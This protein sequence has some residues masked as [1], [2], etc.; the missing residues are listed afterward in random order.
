MAQT[1]LGLHHVTATVGDAQQDLDFCIDLLGLRLVKKT[2]NLDNEKV[3][4]FYYGDEGGTPGSLWT[5]LP[6]AGQGVAKGEKGAGQ[7]VATSFSVPQGSLP[8]WQARFRQHRVLAAPGRARFADE[9]IVFQD[10][11][12]LVFELIADADDRTPWESTIDADHAIRGLHSVTMVVQDPGPTTAFMQ[13]ALGFDV[14]D[15]T[16]GRVRLAAGGSGPGH[17]VDLLYDPK[18]T[19]ASNGIGTVHHVAL[20][21]DSAA[22]QLAIREALVAMGHRVTPVRDRSYFQS[23]YFREPGGVLFEVAT[24]APGFLVDEDL[25]SL[26]TALKLPAW[27]EPHRAAIEAALPAIVHA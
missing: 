27:K 26:G 13:Q 8:F 18:A 23:I 1:V 4:H 25:R 19:R 5:T 14:A 15:E 12:G 16:E 10:P 11:S 20:A 17:L 22:Q 3:Y 6:C 24:V 9:V 7:I 21:A 2:V